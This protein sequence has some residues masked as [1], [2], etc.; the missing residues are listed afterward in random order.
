[1]ME[2][3]L[4]SIVVPVYN[5]EEYLDR[6]LKSITAQT[7]RRLEILLVDDGSSDGSG[8][9]CERWAEEDER[10]LS[11][12]SRLKLAFSGKIHVMESRLQVLEARI[13]SADPRNI[14]KRGYILALDG[15]GVPVKKAAGR[16]PGDR[17]ELMFGDGSVDCEVKNVRQNE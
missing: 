9:L 8:A 3:G 5:T 4:V 14:L 15:R 10:I 1:M 13:L 11:Y 17:L 6:C 2:K 16:H 7:Y 12:A